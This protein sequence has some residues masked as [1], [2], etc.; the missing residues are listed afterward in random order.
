[1]TH[2]DQ[3]QGAVHAGF[4]VQL[5][6]HFTTDLRYTHEQLRKLM[7]SSITEALAAL[8][9]ATGHT[10]EVTAG[11]AYASYSVANHPNAFAAYHERGVPSSDARV[12]VTTLRYQ[13]NRTVYQVKPSVGELP[14]DWQLLRAVGVSEDEAQISRAP[15]NSEATITRLGGGS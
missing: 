3:P 4:D 2:H 15:D 1:M 12:E 14:D 10:F 13:H 6:A 8:T 5:R 11:D 7:R 9:E